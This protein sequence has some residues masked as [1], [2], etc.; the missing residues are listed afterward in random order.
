MQGD[1]SE[2]PKRQSGVYSSSSAFICSWPSRAMRS[3]RARSGIG[4]SWDVK[5]S[6]ASNSWPSEAECQPC[7]PASE[8][9]AVP[10]A[11]ALL[12]RGGLSP[13]FASASM[14]QAVPAAW[15]GLA[16]DVACTRMQL[17]LPG[18]SLLPAEDDCPVLTSSRRLLPNGPSALIKVLAV[19]PCREGGAQDTSAARWQTQLPGVLRAGREVEEEEAVLP[20]ALPGRGQSEGSRGVRG[21]G[22]QWLLWCAP[23]A[24]TL[25]VL[26]AWG[27]GMPSGCVL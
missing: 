2:V 19:L 25:G 14:K 7:L 18:G 21:A 15:W 5:S 12:A 4:R 6:A 1:G 26:G 9:M 17:L 10:V 16:A 8:S 22:G 27:P 3:M 23:L 20:P 24:G 13:A 11:R